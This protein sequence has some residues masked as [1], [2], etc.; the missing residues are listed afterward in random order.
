MF[1]EKKSDLVLIIAVIGLV[2]LSLWPQSGEEASVPDSPADAPAAI[3]GPLPILRDDTRVSEKLDQVLDMVANHQS[4]IDEASASSERQST[5]T[6]RFSAPQPPM[7]GGPLISVTAGTQWR[8]HVSGDAPWVTGEQLTIRLVSEPEG[9]TPGVVETRTDRTVTLSQFH[10]T[11][12][13]V[14]FDGIPFI[15]PEPLLGTRTIRTEGTLLPAQVQLVDGAVWFDIHHRNLIYRYRNKKGKIQE[16][17]AHAIIRN[18]AIAKGFETVIVPAGRF[19]AYR[20]EWLSRLTITAA[21]RPVLEHLTTEPFRRETMW[22]TPGLGIVK[23][24]VDFLMK[25]EKNRTV[26]LSLEGFTPGDDCIFSDL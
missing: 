5:S 20:V 12:D 1:M 14:R 22:L 4:D 8:Y 11:N 17:S 24:E 2:G 9:Q 25:G 10:V 19:G 3:P 26:T 7:N 21:G 6:E 16:L 15:A 13:T 23:R 18:R